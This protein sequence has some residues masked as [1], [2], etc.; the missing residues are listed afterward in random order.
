MEYL[1]TSLKATV[2]VAETLTSK[3][4]KGARKA[5]LKRVPFIKWDNATDDRMSMALERTDR[6][7]VIAIKLRDVELNSSVCRFFWSLL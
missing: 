6:G 1:K 5:I 7:R 2:N 4:F 3:A